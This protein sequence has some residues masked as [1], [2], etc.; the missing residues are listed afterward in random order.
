MQQIC[1]LFVE[2]DPDYREAFADGLSDHGFSVRS[3]PDGAALLTSL[4]AAAAADVIVLDWV[5]PK[6]SGIDLLSQLRQRGV[7]LPVVFLTV[8]GYVEYENLAFA[9]GASDFIDKGRGLEV[10]ARRLRRAVETATAGGRLGGGLVSSKL[11][12]N[13]S[14]SRAYWGDV[15]V[16]LTLSEYKLVDLLVSNAG[17]YVS[18]RAIYDRMHYKGFRAGSGNRGYRTNVRSSIKRIR[19]KFCEIDPT[20]GQIQTFTAFGYRWRGP[21]PM[22][23]TE[24]V[25]D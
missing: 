22:Q 5:L 8:Y 19:R 16:N 10:V 24:P 25:P 12:L 9:Q 13:P 1:V 20:F 2:D 11:V 17:R 6:V 15:D 3:F 14:V 21:V 4:N 23:R 7:T 18:Y